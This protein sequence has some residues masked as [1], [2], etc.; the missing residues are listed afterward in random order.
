LSEFDVPGF[1]TSVIDGDVINGVPPQNNFAMSSNPRAAAMRNRI[2]PGSLSVAPAAQAPQ[3][4]PN[5]S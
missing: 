5:E 4:T 2:M 1:A 3:P